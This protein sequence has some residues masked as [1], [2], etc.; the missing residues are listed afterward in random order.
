M[1][2]EVLSLQETMHHKGEKYIYTQRATLTTTISSCNDMPAKIRHL[3]KRN[4]PEAVTTTISM[5]ASA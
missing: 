3:M 5:P 4:A 1:V 2:E